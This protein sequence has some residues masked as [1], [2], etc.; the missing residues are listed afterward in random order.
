[1]HS[2]IQFVK[3]IR[4]H[5]GAVAIVLCGGVFLGAIRMFRYG[6]SLPFSFA[7][8]VGLFVITALVLYLVLVAISYSG[9]RHKKEQ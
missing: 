9:K 4:A 8:G 3:K 6:D 7:V 5:K 2:L 1:M